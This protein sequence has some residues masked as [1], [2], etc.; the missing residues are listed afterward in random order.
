MTTF[1]ISASVKDRYRVSND[2][3]WITVEGDLNKP[4]MGLEDYPCSRDGCFEG[5]LIMKYVTDDG[6][7]MIFP[8]ALSSPIGFQRR[9]R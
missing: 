2:G 5:M 4:T 1:R 3:P 8:L 6:M 7:E 9:G